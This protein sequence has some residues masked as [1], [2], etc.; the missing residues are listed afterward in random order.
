MGKFE[1]TPDTYFK[2]IDEALRLVPKEG[3]EGE[4]PCPVCKTGTIKWIR[5]RSNKHL[6]MGCNTP[7]CVLLIQ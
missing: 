3:N 6:R 1:E 5:V 2:G 7:D 4:F